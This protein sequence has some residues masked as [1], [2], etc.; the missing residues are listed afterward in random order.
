[1]CDCVLD[2]TGEGMLRNGFAVLCGINCSLS[3]L[4]DTCALQRGYLNNLAAELA[5]KLCSVDLVARLLD[6]I[7]HVNSN[8]DGNAK[9]GELCGEVQV[10]FEVCTVDYVEDGVGAFTDE[11]ISRDNFLKCVRGK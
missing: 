8:N 3:R 4:H 1:M 5:C 7:H 10:S 6:N 2:N 11:V 9:L